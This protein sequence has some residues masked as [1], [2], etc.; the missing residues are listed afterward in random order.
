MKSIKKNIE[1]LHPKN[2]LNLFGYNIFFDLFTKLYETKKLPNSILLSGSKG[3]GKS[4][5]AYH[6]ANYLLSKNEKDEYLIKNF[7]INKENLSYKYICNDTHPNFFLIENKIDEK[8]I[9]IDKIV[10]KKFK[11][12]FD[13]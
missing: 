1:I 10:F 9:K 11:D 12:C 13:R 7:T 8:E 2:Q 5:F 3:S 4:T 6:F